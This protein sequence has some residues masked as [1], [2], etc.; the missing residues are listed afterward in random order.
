MPAPG[1]AG[2]G[3]GA[4]GGAAAG[5]VTHPHP[6]STQ[7]LGPPKDPSPGAGRQPPFCRVTQ[8]S[9]SRAGEM[10]RRHLSGE[11]RRL[12]A[13]LVCRMCCIG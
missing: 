11:E 9:P 12:S 3:S 1:T 10:E 6:R 2:V 7:R 5:E 4:V 8:R 13:C